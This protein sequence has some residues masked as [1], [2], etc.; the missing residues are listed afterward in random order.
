M[1]RNKKRAFTIVELVIS[2]SVVAVL[3][4]VLV[5]TFSNVIQNAKVSSDTQLVRNL[6]T[7]LAADFNKHNTMSDAVAAVENFGMDLQQ[8]K[9]S[10]KGHRILWDRKN[11]VFCYQD[12]ENICYVPPKTLDFPQSEVEV[13]Q[14]N[15]VN[16][17]DYWIVAE[18][19]EDMQSGYSFLYQPQAGELPETISV[20]F[21]AGNVQNL[22]VNYARAAD[23]TPQT[24]VIRTNGGILNVNA[25]TDSILHF[26]MLDLLNIEQIA[27]SSFV[28]LGNTT[29]A[30][31]NS[32][33]Y[34]VS[35]ANPQPQIYVASQ[36]AIIAANENT[37]LNFAGRDSAVSSFTF[38]VVRLSSTVA[39]HFDVTSEVVIEWTEG[40]RPMF[41]QNGEITQNV[42]SAISR[43]EVEESLSDGVAKENVFVEA[44]PQNR[45]TDFALLHSGEAVGE[46]ITIALDK[47]S[48]AFATDYFEY[49]GLFAPTTAVT[50]SS[51][52]ASVATVE[53]GVVTLHDGG[54]T[55]I[56][57]TAVASDGLSR[58]V[59]LVV[60]EVTGLSVT[61]CGAP[62]NDG[63]VIR[64]EYPENLAFSLQTS[65]SYNVANVE[66]V[67]VDD[68]ITFQTS[69]E[70][71]GISNNQINVV[72]EKFGSQQVTVEVP[73]YNLSKTFTVEV[74][75]PTKTSF[76]CILDNDGFLY[77]LGNANSVSVGSLFQ[78]VPGI[79]FSRYE[80][81]W[82]NVY[83]AAQTCGDGTRMPVETD[84]YFG[85]TQSKIE[86]SVADVLNKQITFFGTGVAIVEIGCVRNGEFVEETSATVAVEIV[87]GQTPQYQSA[88]TYV[89][90]KPQFAYNGQT[91]AEVINYTPQTISLASSVTKYGKSLPVT[92]FVGGEQVGNAY[93]F[94]GWGE[95]VVTFV[96]TDD[97]VFDEN[98]NRLPSVEYRWTRTIK[99]D[100]YRFYFEGQDPNIYW[101]SRVDRGVTGYAPAVP[102]LQSLRVEKNGEVIYNGK[103]Q[104]TLPA[105]IKVNVN[106]FKSC[107]VVDFFVRTKFD[108]KILYATAKNFN[109]WKRYVCD[110]NVTYS[111]TTELGTVCNFVHTWHFELADPWR[112]QDYGVIKNDKYT[113]VVKTNVNIQGDRVFQI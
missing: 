93:T 16:K 82:V 87:D 109:P 108:E 24:V 49:E 104:I 83:D 26:G 12:G 4:A 40:G 103:N 65:L 71:F 60:V 68:Q 101:L 20:G 19:A 67:D 33:R 1:Q 50:W 48:L 11:D 110:I 52:N 73:S 15:N 106:G 74:K 75:N 46:T 39:E 62:C 94:A 63:D 77:R 76:A 42:A 2:I 25:P 112:A 85:A 5:P 31:V 38:Q 57:A 37:Q 59:R 92:T 6:N 58:S 89:V 98:G 86:S 72:E 107:D 78:K 96:A 53:N 69:G 10:A 51:D 64:L 41:T 84:G 56:S 66:G 14:A 23:A 30:V 113:S 100:S 99:V 70:V 21:D 36:N 44:F 80:A 35:Q 111:F 9:A 97:M 7:A 102:V 3:A 81:V 43:P 17:V 45:I 27:K 91:Q 34:V 8:L 28:E 54:E 32:G 13:Y 18:T 90:T 61:V 79:V 88:H 47:Q 55:T 95:Y 22:T 29:L 105:Q